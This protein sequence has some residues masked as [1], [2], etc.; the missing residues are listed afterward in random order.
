MHLYFRFFTENNKFRIEVVQDNIQYLDCQ[1]KG[2][3]DYWFFQV[4]E[5]HQNFWMTINKPPLQ[6]DGQ[7]HEE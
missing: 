4:Q 7:K 5:I 3:N 6:N 1:W 2:K